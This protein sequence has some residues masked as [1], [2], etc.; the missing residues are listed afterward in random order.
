MEAQP[1][2]LKILVCDDD[3]ADRKLVRTYLRQMTDRE[4]VLLEAGQIAEIQNA[5][6]K[7]RVDLVLMDIQMPEKSGME[8]LAEIVEKETAPVIMMTGSGSEEI[9]VRSLQEGAVGYLPK[10]SLS[11][12]NL[13]KTI[14]AALEKWRRMQQGKADQEKLERLANFDLLT[15]L[16]NRRAILRR[17]E[18]QIKHANR[19]K[20][21]LSLIMLDLDHFKEVNDHYGHLTGDDVLESVATLVRQSIRDTDTAGRYGGEEFIIVL[22]KTDLPTALYVAERIREAIAAAE[23][24]DSEGNVFSITVSQ[25]L[26]S[27]EPGEDEHSL[28]SRADVALYR[29]KEGGRNRVETSFS[30][31]LQK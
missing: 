28:I 26:S 7:G 22:P 15:G 18:E 23:M 21:E 8:W 3:P 16:E 9:A 2:L 20:E 30:F 11:R 13:M 19:Y 10:S 17:L 4:I 31:E 12:E 29:A 14:D 5:L 6:D 27:Y 25:G 1:S 24:R